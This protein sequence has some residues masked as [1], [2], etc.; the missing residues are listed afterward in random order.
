MITAMGDLFGLLDAHG[1][2]F[3]RTDHPAVFTVEEA[4]RL[5]PPL[6]ATP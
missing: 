5:V 6:P 2:Q 1:I 4:R 3:Q